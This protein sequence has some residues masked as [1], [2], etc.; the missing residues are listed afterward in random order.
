M[1]VKNLVDVVSRRGL[2]RRE[3][4][5][6]EFRSAT[7]ERVVLIALLGDQRLPAGELGGSGCCRWIAQACKNS[8]VEVE[9]SR[10]AGVSP[11]KWER[12]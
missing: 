7:I 10:Q 6:N 1:V 3:R 8:T 4:L 11:N 2:R 9:A 12:M 5:G